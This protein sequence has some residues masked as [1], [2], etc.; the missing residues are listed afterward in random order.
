MIDLGINRASDAQRKRLAAIR[1]TARKLAK[2]LDHDHDPASYVVALSFEP[3]MTDATAKTARLSAAAA[4][5]ADRADA[6]L[7]VYKREARRQTATYLAKFVRGVAVICKET[8]G[9]GGL[10]RGTDTSS[11]LAAGEPGGVLLR[12]LKLLY[13]WAGPPHSTKSDE[14]IAKDIRRYLAADISRTRE[15]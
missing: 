10:T 12:L 4:E 13:G 1:D 15:R 6:L 5:I 14:G 8:T 11:D 3:E 9:R 7:P 2:L